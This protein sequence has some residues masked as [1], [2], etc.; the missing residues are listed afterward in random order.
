MF[1]TFGF[2]SAY[3]AVISFPGVEFEV[4]RVPSQ[5]VEVKTTLTIPL[6]VVTLQ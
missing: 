2:L 3:C 5:S 1:E 6:V 4:S